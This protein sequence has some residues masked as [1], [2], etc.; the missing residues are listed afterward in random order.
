MRRRIDSK[1]FALRCCTAMDDDD[2]PRV[3]G[4]AASQLAKESLDTYSQDELT[5]R[6]AAA[7][8]RNRADQGASRAGWPTI[9]RPPTRCSGRERPTDG[10]PPLAFASGRSHIG[11]RWSGRIATVRRSVPTVST[12]G[13]YHHA[14]GHARSCQVSPRAS[15]KPCT[16]RCRTRPTAATNMPRWSTCCWRWSKTPTP[17]K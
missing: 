5:A 17:P 15:K 1:R 14:N 12:F 7:R 2:L 3:R 9:A 11:S 6:I 10:R 13:S 4:D 16:A 8:S